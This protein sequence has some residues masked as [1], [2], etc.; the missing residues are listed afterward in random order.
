MKKFD[1]PED[2]NP[3]G[4]SPRSALE[5]GK[6]ANAWSNGA[7]AARCK[8]MESSMVFKNQ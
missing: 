3:S 7:S 6:V 2:K 8:V 5:S 4:I 1:L